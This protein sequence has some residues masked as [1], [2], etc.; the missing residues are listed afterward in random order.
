MKLQVRDPIKIRTLEEYRK[1][2]YGCRFCPMCKPASD[3]ANVTFLES[4]TTRARA[5]MLWRILNGYSD[6]SE[7]D[8]ELLYQSTLD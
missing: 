8:V 5:M 2:L 7:R 4:H 1:Y 6:F 3:V